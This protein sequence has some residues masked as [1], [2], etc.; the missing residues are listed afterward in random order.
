MKLNALRI[1]NFR[2]LKN[3]V[4]DLEDTITIFVGANNS[5]K[6]SAT[7]ALD[8][9][10]NGPREKISIFD[11]SSDCWSDFTAIGENGFTPELNALPVINLDLWF[12][13]NAQ[14]LHRIRELLPG[15]EWED[16]EIGLRIQFQPKSTEE[17]ILHF[18]EARQKVAAYVGIEGDTYHPWPGKLVDYLERELT[19]EYH[20][21]YYALDRAHFDAGYQENQDFDPKCRYRP[22]FLY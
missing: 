19:G 12:T 7:Q 6:T 20:F 3:V 15:L 4:I 5:G 21:G 22:V 18:R 14:N 13:V 17:L 2:R 9:F 8:L 1:Q 10:I 11:F 16:S